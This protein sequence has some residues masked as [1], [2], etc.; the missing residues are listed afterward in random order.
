MDDLER[1]VTDMILRVDNFGTENAVRI[2]VNPLAVGKFDLVQTF[3][4]QILNTGEERSSASQMKFSQTAK[5]Q[6]AR[7]EVKKEVLEIAKTGRD[8]QRNNP[9]FNN[10]FHIQENNRNDATLLETA[11]QFHTDASVAEVKEL[12]L[13]YAMPDDFLEDLAAA[14]AAFEAAVSKQDTANR[15]RIDANASIDDLTV[16]VLAAV[17]TLKIIV[18]KL[19]RDEPGKLA[20]WGSASHVEKAPTKK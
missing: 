4:T 2:R 19:F 7:D 8:I 9:D 18:P 1:N 16:Q 6:I 11:R 17:R 5:R 13:A 14:I 10:V 15:D 12:F 20:D 3:I